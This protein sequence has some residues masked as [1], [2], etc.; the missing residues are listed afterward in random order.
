MTAT[1][2][3]ELG[4]I[5]E[6]ISRRERPENESTPG[7]FASGVSVSLVAGT[8]FILNLRSRMAQGPINLIRENF[9]MRTPFCAS[10]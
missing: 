8:R 6:W 4:T 5:L 1:L 7:A 9:G 3:D 2:H 10:A